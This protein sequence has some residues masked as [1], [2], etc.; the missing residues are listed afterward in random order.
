M[1]GKLSVSIVIPAFNEEPTIGS[2]VR[3][4]LNVDPSLEVIVVDDGSS[5]S[6][7]TCAGEAGGIVIRHPYNMGNGAAIKSGVRWASNDV[8]VLMDADG[9]HDP[10]DVPSLLA[11][12]HD[13]DMVVAAR[14]RKSKVSAFR[15]GGNAILTA[16][17]AA[18][19]GHK[20]VDLTSGFRAIRREALVTYLHLL[21]NRFSYP[22][23]IT[24]AMFRSG[25]SVKYVPMDTIRQRQGGVS[26]LHPFRDG[27][28]M[29]LTIVRVVAVFSPLRVFIPISALLALYGMGRA[30]TAWFGQGSVA[31]A[32]APLLLSIAVFCAG[33][34][35]DRRATLRRAP[36]AG[37]S[38]DVRPA[39]R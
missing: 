34:L 25:Y 6:T 24:I 19:S 31:G 39:N 35:A 13:V 37:K 26:K 29:I 33:I 15:A 22:T 36:H 5:D 12:A 4:L 17:A 21:P 16:F 20:I 23:T 7:A 14:T 30:A 3:G 38:I 2:I 10:S 9:Q 27:A 28:R 1:E 18:L 11:H 8:I 32:E